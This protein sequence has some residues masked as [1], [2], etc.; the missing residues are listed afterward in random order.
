MKITEKAYLNYGVPSHWIDNYIDKGLTISA[1]RATSK[2]NLLKRYGI[3]DNEVDFVKTCL[4]RE[5]IDD[6]TLQSLLESS[7]F[8]CCLCKGTKGTSYIIHHI[9]EYSKSQDNNYENLAVLCPSHHDDAHKQGKTLTNK[10]TPD[11]IRKAKSKWEKL[12]EKENVRRATL[13]GDIHEI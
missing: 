5:P 8:L 1:F 3:P 4:K 11:N 2:K 7:N 9:E 12:V 10:I 6:N 13:N